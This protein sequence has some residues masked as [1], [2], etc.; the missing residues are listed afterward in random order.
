MSDLPVDVVVSEHCPP[1]SL[2]IVNPAKL[3]GGELHGPHPDLLA[4]LNKERVTIVCPDEEEAAKIRD[5]ARFVLEPFTVPEQPS[6]E[7]QEPTDPTNMGEFPRLTRRAISGKDDRI[8]CR[9]GE[10]NCGSQCC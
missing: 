10:C 2:L 1:G 3:P 8:P 5:Q 7:E 6:S 4:S 9:P